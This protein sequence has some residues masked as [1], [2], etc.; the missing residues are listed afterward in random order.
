M[1]QGNVSRK[2]GM[3]IVDFPV[4]LVLVLLVHLLRMQGF[5]GE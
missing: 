2:R 5:Y 3:M 4:V 1:K